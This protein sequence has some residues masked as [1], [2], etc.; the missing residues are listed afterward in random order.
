MLQLLQLRC[1]RQHLFSKGDVTAEFVGLGRAERERELPTVAHIHFNGASGNVAAGKYNDGSPENRPVMAKRMAAAMR[2]AWDATQKT[3]LPKQIE[4]R[5]VP[6][7]LPQRVPA[8]RA[9]LEKTLYDPN[10]KF[11]ARRAAAVQL[12]FLARAETGYKHPLNCLRLGDKY[13]VLM[14]GELFI[15]YQL[16]A[17]KMR[18]NDKVMMAAYGDYGPGYIGTAIAYTQGGYEVGPNAS[19][20][21]PQVEQVLMNGLRQLLR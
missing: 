10:A 18:P 2:S 3:A 20:V 11:E 16:A 7:T 8:T 15:E 13:V 5:T 19:L 12:S 6:V 1:S 14:P 4:W 21:A 9:D 17:R